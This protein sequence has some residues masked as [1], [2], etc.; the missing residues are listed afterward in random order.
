MSRRAT[1]DPRTPAQTTN[2]NG[3]EP[4]REP[5]T[6]TRGR[7]ARHAR[8]RARS[9]SRRYLRRGL[10]AFGVVVVLVAGAA[11]GDYYYLGSLVHHQDVRGLQVNP[12][13]EPSLNILMIGSTSRCALKTQNAAYGLCSQGVTGVNS[14]IDMILH[15]DPATG[16]VSLLSIPRDL[17]VPNA[18]AEGAN[19]ID[20]ALY[21]GPSQL[22]DAIEEDF[23]IPINHYVEL[24]FD[25]FASVVNALGG[26]RMYFPVPIFDAYSG[27]NIERKGCY[28]LN[29]YRAL[30]VVRA[31]HLQIQPNPS[32]HDPRSWPQEALSD[33]ARIRRT[34]E[35]LRVMASQVAQRGLSN[36]FTD[37]RIASAV[38]PDLTVDNGF[39]EGLMVHLARVFSHVSIANVPQLT[40][41]VTLVETGSY[42]YQ[43]YYYGDVEFPVEPTG[44]LAIDQLFGVG[45]TTNSFTGQP[46]PAANS[47][48]VAVEDGA[49]VPS[50]LG[51]TVVGL[52]QRGFS[53]SSA[54]TVTPVGR[55]DETVVWY[56][57]P[58]PPAHGNWT[59][60]ALAAAQRVERTL[61]GPVIMGYNPKMVVPGSL[62]TVVAGTG[63]TFVPIASTTTTT[64]P[65]TTTT[66]VTTT[67]SPNV[68][69]STIFDPS[70]IKSN[71]LFTPPSPTSTALAPYD[72]R[73]CN[74]AGTGPG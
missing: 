6:R 19:K 58:P 46:L 7:R 71:P 69:T 17:F 66:N 11:V 60:P 52:R 9:R 57:G 56:G 35:F 39:S 25:T 1:G 73:A 49:G 74:A 21:E 36:P 64:V 55:V 4:P 41:P 28:L 40:Y 47:F 32:N 15:L 62:V 33:L 70:G 18:R 29:G 38:L 34:H 72:P 13:S 3:V 53:V 48:K 44:Q 8:A 2:A 68:T 43:G 54:S 30:Q 10:I 20:A 63:L 45:A 14:D 65:H 31:R 61:E 59:S 16:A 50:E 26:V 22:V 37:Q 27:L 24:N 12:S 23:G 51:A 67:T 5:T 42:L